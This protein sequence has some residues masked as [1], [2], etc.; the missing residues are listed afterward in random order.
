MTI[1]PAYASFT[2]T[3]LGSLEPGK[4][5]DFVVLSQNIIDEKLVT[6]RKILETRVLATVIDGEVIYGAL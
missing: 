2:E 4:Q 6:P 3:Y 5:A 1:D